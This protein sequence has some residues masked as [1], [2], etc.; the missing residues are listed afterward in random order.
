[1]D[2]DAACVWTFILYM[3]CLEKVISA[4]T[5][6]EYSE[7]N[8]PCTYFEG[9]RRAKYEPGLV[10]CSWYSSSSCCKRTEVTSVFASNMMPLYRASVDCRNRINYMMCYFCSPDQFHW[11]KEGKV[12]VCESFCASIHIECREAFY[13]GKQIGDAYRNGTAFCEAQNFLVTNSKSCFKFDAN[14]FDASPPVHISLQMLS[15]ALVTVT[16]ARTMILSVV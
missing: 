14:V 2:T 11:Y 10:N 8:K 5:V 9:T 7:D 6:I 16:L 1:M 13:N 15:G 12:H 3:V 4:E